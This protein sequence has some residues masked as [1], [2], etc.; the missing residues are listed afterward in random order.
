VD[1]EITVYEFRDGSRVEV[2]DPTVV[3]M[4][5]VYVHKQL[6]YTNVDSTHE[7]VFEVRDGLPGCVSI[8][9]LSDENLFNAKGLAKID[10]LRDEVFAVFG[11][12]RQDSDGKW[13]RRL[14]ADEHDMP[15]V[16]AQAVSPR[17][18]NDEFLSR[19]AQVH[20]AAPVGKRTEA[21]CAEFGVSP[22]T[23]WRYTAQARKKG[24]IK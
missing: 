21:I 14:L 24:L 16:I 10:K 17:K 19:V 20:N 5:D 7:I 15:A 22:R 11:V 2:T 9:M 4:G 8:R 1:V 6:T 13:V 23:A 18:L 3:P 12:L